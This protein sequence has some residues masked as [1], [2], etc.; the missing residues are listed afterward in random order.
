MYIIPL[1]ILSKKLPTPTP[2]TLVLLIKTLLL[3]PKAALN[4]MSPEA[5]DVSVS[6]L[7]LYGT[8]PYS[9]DEPLDP[10]D[11]LDPDEP[12]D[13]EEPLEPDEPEDPLEPEAPDEPLEPATVKPDVPEEPL[14]PVAPEDPLEPEAPE[15]PEDPSVPELPEEPLDPEAPDDPLEPELPDEPPP[16]LGPLGASINCTSSLAVNISPS[17]LVTVNSL[18]AD[19]DISPD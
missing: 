3:D 5:G 4:C 14:E 2:C 7:N 19:D 13:P 11:P 6:V 16:P 18:N 15:D 8:P 9:P 10:E 1:L 17:P 12:E